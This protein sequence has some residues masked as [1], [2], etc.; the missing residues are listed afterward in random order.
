MHSWPWVVM[1]MSDEV[2]VR[3][4]PSFAGTMTSATA[5]PGH[6]ELGEALGHVIHEVHSLGQRV[7]FVL[8]VASVEQELDDLVF[9]EVFAIVEHVPSAVESTSFFV[10][11]IASLLHKLD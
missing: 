9:V 6:I 8:L 11:E 2:L 7:V 1:V 3:L 4:L 10:H 5:A